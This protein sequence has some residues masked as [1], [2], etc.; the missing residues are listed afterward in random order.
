MSE[1]QLQADAKLAASLLKCFVAAEKQTR[2]L[3]V[4]T[5]LCWTSL[6]CSSVGRL[7]LSPWLPCRCCV[8]WLWLTIQISCWRQRACEWSADPTGAALMKP[9]PASFNRRSPSCFW[10][11]LSWRWCGRGEPPAAASSAAGRPVLRLWAGTAASR[12]L[13]PPSWRRGSQRRRS[14]PP[15][16]DALRRH[17]GHEV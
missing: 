6:T 15:R 1:V 2:R 17:H 10:G 13:L 4:R 9:S 8:F 11:R 16:P 14:T 7:L 5:F 12:G 3:F